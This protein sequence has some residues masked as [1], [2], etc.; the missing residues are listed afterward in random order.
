[1]Q[2]AICTYLISITRRTRSQILLFESKISLASK[3][4]ANV[5][6]N[7]V[8][9]GKVDFF[10]FNWTFNNALVPR[11]VNIHLEF[12]HLVYTNSCSDGRTRISNGSMIPKLVD[13]WVCFYCEFD[14]IFFLL[15]QSWVRTFWFTS[16]WSRPLPVV[17]FR[18]FARC[19]RWRVHHNPQVWC[20]KVFWFNVSNNERTM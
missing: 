4:V 16:F 5:F 8:Y 14:P 10:F 12:W 1:M 15:I 13:F 7:S 11:R 17:T 20:C 18:L 9:F 19:L 2:S 6:I 3:Y